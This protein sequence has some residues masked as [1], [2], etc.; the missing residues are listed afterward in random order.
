MTYNTRSANSKGKEK[1]KEVEDIDDVKEITV[2]LVRE[3]DQ[4]CVLSQYGPFG[5][6][7]CSGNPLYV[8]T[9]VNVPTG[10]IVR[11]GVC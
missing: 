3:A 11:Y 7:S 6:I 9:P 5:D 8:F 4:P 1:E 2:E 10:F